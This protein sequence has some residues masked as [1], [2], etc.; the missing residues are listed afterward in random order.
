[1]TD[2]EEEYEGV[3]IYVDANNSWPSNL[4]GVRILEQTAMRMEDGRVKI[5]GDPVWS[6]E[7]PD[8]LD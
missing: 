6:V 7:A 8:E 2:H 4:A 1:M 5:I 3:T